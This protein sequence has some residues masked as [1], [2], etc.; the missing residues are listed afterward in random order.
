MTDTIAQRGEYMLAIQQT[1]IYRNKLF[2]SSVAVIAGF[3]LTVGLIRAFTTPQVTQ[4]SVQDGRR[5]TMLLPI[6]ASPSEKNSESKRSEDSSKSGTPAEGSSS[7]STLSL[8]PSGSHPNT[9]SQ[10]STSDGMSSP[11]SS[12]TTTQ[13][14]SSDGSASPP[15]TTVTQPTS[16]DQGTTTPQKNCVLDILGINLICT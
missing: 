12:S 13:P 11:S 16:G 7:S 2:V 6:S 4:Q 15:T 14:S 5:S 1:P 9:T 3:L 10:S 8:Q